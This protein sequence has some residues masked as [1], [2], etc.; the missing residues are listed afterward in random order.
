M[1]IEEFDIE[2]FTEE[3]DLCPIAQ[4]IVIVDL[5]KFTVTNGGC[6]CYSDCPGDCGCYKV[7][8]CDGNCGMTW[9]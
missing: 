7:C 6:G 5:S 4:G 2:L 8:G 9:Q 1:I 3:S